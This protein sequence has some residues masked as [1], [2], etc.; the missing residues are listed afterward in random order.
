MNKQ[1]QDGFGDNLVG[2][3]CW[4]VFRGESGTCAHCTND[5]L[6]DADGHPSGVYIWEGQ[7]P[8][9]ARWYINYD[10]AIKWV[11]D[12]LARL[13]VATDI[14]ERKQAEEERERLLAQIQEQARQVQ[15]IIVTVPE[16]VFL[17][18]AD[19]RVV[20]ANPVAEQ[21]LL[22]LSD[23]KVGDTL[24]RLG[25]RPLAELL[26]SPPQGLWHE[27]KADERTFEVI[28]RPMENGPE[29]EDWVL[30]INDVTREREIQQRIQ[31]QERLAAVGQLAAG[32]A[33]D[34]NNVMAT[35]VL[36]AQM[37]AR[38]EGLSATIRE[39]MATINQQAQHATK[40][41]QQI[42][43]FARRAVLERRPMDL[44][45]LLKEQVE[46]LERTV[47]ESI[48]IKLDYGSD[49][50]TVHADPTRMQQMVMNLAVNARDAM[51]EGGSLRIGL[52]RIRIEGRKAA[53]LPEMEPGEWVQ[54]TVSDTGIGIP[55]DV[56]PRIY[57]PFFT[58]R[59]PLGSGLGLAQVH[60]IVAQHEGYIDVKTQLGQGTT[61][62]IYLPALLV[63]QPETPTRPAAR[64]AKGEGQT[65]LVVEDNAATRQAL[66]ESLELLDYQV[67][68][69]S[70]GQ[71]ALTIFEQHTDKASHD[72]GQ[73]ALVLSD[74]V[75]PGM[76]GIALFHTL[77]EKCPR[78]QMVL[79]T[80]HPMEDELE[81]LR[82]QGLSGW[83]LKP[84]SLEQ[85]AEVVARA[86]GEI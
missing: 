63:H 73:I 62:I 55:P 83:L 35:I 26:T 70:N 16:G 32:I 22:L 67:L 12:R 48:G 56:L 33:H 57:E 61:F 78:V 58:T 34:F 65:I 8:I 72:A 74:V 49:D 39:R 75:M 47:P 68:E 86:L 19:G 1:M 25:D 80:G 2:K 44:L 76:G 64:L 37:T 51:P 66:A 42:L 11:D 5:Q 23:A 82:A 53:P 15:Q 17:L 60:G 41:T 81:N 54:V 10:R 30:V 24:T 18:D 43:D 9:T 46:L 13:Q 69:A 31:Q 40:L 20:L 36:Y 21:I 7:N 4:K 14:T 52:E 38:T 6:L 28:A 79:L 45:L 29:P 71:Q 50:Y 85:L 27:V 3:I 84:P 59:A 77:R